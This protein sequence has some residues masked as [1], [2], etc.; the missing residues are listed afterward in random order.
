M[1]GKE[2]MMSASEEGRRMCRVMEAGRMARGIDK[3]EGRLW[4]IEERSAGITRVE[5]KRL[6]SRRKGG[7][8]GI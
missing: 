7:V 5:K 2:V 3:G 6:V 8:H 4:M 1:R